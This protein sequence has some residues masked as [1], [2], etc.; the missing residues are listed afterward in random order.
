MAAAN[1]GKIGVAAVVGPTGSGKTA[2]ACSLAERFDLTIICA[3]SMQIYEG[4]EIASA[5]PDPEERRSAPHR[6]FGIKQPDENFSVADY[7]NLA[8]KEISS[9]A[10]EGRL[11]CIVGGTGLYI[12]SLLCG[13]T[14]SDEPSDGGVLRRRLTEEAERV[15]YADM[16]ERLR[17]I[18]PETAARL[19]ENDRKRII[20]AFEVYEL[21]G[22]TPSE[23]NKMSREKESPYTSAVIGVTYKDREKLYSRI[24]ERVDRMLESGLVEEAKRLRSRL[25]ATAVQAIGHK[26]IYPF[27][28]GSISLDEAAENLKRATR[29]YAKRQLTWFNRNKDIYWI[30]MDECDDPTGEAERYIRSSLPQFVSGSRSD[31]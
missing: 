25:G 19:H 13:R 12:D 1:N 21:H 5:A 15:G 3:D 22:I 26:E 11:P 20:R 30:Y 9:V 27:I 17:A 23:F 2:L 29:R 28:D 4:M 18:D 8:S 7:V 31:R 16:L 24:N 6:L 10:E 14:F